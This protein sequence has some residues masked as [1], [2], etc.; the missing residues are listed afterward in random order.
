MDTLD[1]SDPE[2]EDDEVFSYFVNQF[3]EV[4]ED[5]FRFHNPI[6]EQPQPSSE[7]VKFPVLEDRSL[8]E[9]DVFHSQPNGSDN[10]SRRETCPPWVS[11]RTPLSGCGAHGR[12]R[13]RN[14]NRNESRTL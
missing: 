1:W 9:G 13:E 10:R 5:D 11:I 4:T 3:S 6:S 2:E 12:I 7:H 14:R 8:G